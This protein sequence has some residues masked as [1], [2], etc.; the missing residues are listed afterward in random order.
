MRLFVWT[1]CCWG[2]LIGIAN[3][4][5][6]SRWLIVPSS[7]DASADWMESAT[8]RARG[9]LVQQ[10]QDVWALDKAAAKFEELV[11]SPPVVLSKRERQRW[12]ATSDGAV[13]DLAEGNHK[14]ALTKLNAAQSLSRKAIEDLNRDPE[15]ARRVF[16]TCLYVVRA[17][18]ATESESRARSVARECR[19]LVPRAE[20]SPYMHPPAVTGLL[21][22]I[23]ASQARQT[24][25]LRLESSP[26]GCS[27]RLN[28]VLLGETPVSIGKLFPGQYRVQIE[29]DPSERG[30]VHLVAV[31]AGQT[32]R[33]VD[34]RFDDVVESRPSLHLRYTDASDE[35]E[36]RVADALR[37]AK[38]LEA[39][40]LV[41]LSM[42]T[43]DTMQLERIER[44]AREPMRLVAIARVSVG[45]GGPAAS[46]L[47]AA[48]RTL[49][50]GECTD[51]TS[52]E[53]QALP[54]GREQAIGTSSAPEPNDRPE[55]RRPRGQFISGITVASVGIAGLVTG[56]A[57]LIPR[58]SA[59]EDWIVAVDGG[60]EGTAAQQG[61]FDL[62]GGIIASGSVGSAALITA[63]P[64]ALPERDKTPWWA[65]MSGGVGLGLAGFSI[66]WGVMADASPSVSCSSPTL[67][68][69]VPRACVQHSEQTVLAV[70]TG[71]TAAPLITMPLVYLFRPS[72]APLEPQVQLGR[73]GAY[74]GLRGRF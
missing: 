43:A 6:N 8:G 31:G 47:V 55:G 61:W 3:A 59:A 23:D 66:A 70:L 48:A 36:H 58:S 49:T 35:P 37:I 10:G 60:S 40:N 33:R 1:L 41:L 14:Q 57:L 32:E 38:A 74:L 2:L 39:G 17:V 62:R 52:A 7:S 28:G 12:R 50:A 34:S 15:Q 20:P 71:L 73:S 56:Y 4:E 21:G 13:E 11:S 26:S 18:L 69:T 24:G 72:R 51:F 64:L 5:T 25:A 46:D 67:D 16:D 42:P 68:P 22:Q 65:W 54:C 45:S 27:A 53:P 30:R 63:M 9:A 44:A 29:C 19:Q